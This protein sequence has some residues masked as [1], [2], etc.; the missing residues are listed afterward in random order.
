MPSISD[1]GSMNS[2]VWVITQKPFEKD[3]DKGFLFSSPMGYVFDKMMRD[4]GFSDYFAISIQPDLD[5]PESYKNV[6]GH[7]G[8][9]QPPIIIC[10]DNAGLKF[11]PEL[12]PKRQGKDYDPEEDSEISKYCGSLLSS[13]KLDYPHYMVPTYGA[14]TIVKQWKERDIVISCDL[15]RAKAELD[16]WSKYGSI[17]PLPQ[18]K[19]QIEFDSFDEL[20]SI[21][22]SFL[23]S[24]NEVILSYLSSILSSSYLST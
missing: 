10:L 8:Q 5:H 4:A 13:A 7:L 22:L 11:L 23:D 14:D 24:P 6:H 15:S 9:F 17:Q 19:C 1:R 20:C 16:Y 3:R 2:R 21:I 18:R 12:V